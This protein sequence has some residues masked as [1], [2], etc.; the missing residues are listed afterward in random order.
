MIHFEPIHCDC[1]GKRA[2]GILRRY[3]SGSFEEKSPYVSA[4]TVIGSGS[5]AT[6]K[7]FIGCPV[8]FHELWDV[9]RAEGYDRVEW[10]RAD[11]HHAQFLITRPL[12]TKDSV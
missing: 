1:C 12:V 6:I 5:L 9:L 3:T 7:G 8:S 11:G 4:A 10:F 2:G